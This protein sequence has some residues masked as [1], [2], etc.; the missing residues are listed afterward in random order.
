MKL[1]S[2]I[3]IK[4]LY[5][6]SK[7]SKICSLIALIMVIVAINTIANYNNS[8]ANEFF[9][10]PLNKIKELAE[11]KNPILI[12]TLAFTIIEFLIC[13]V[14]IFITFHLYKEESLLPYKS[15]IRKIIIFSFISAFVFS[16]IFSWIV[17]K[18]IKKIKSNKK[19]EISPPLF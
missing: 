1:N 19:E 7:I 13:F 5:I 18:N 10:S 14:I 15:N 4:L 3:L 9:T 8:I 16:F 11:Q 2:N 17:D 6:F 12:T